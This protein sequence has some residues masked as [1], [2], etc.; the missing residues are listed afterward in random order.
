MAHLHPRVGF[1]VELGDA[2]RLGLL[3]ALLAPVVQDDGVR[4]AVPHE[5]GR[6][7]REGRGVSD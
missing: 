5:E 1:E 3:H 4:I 6:L 2:E 7:L